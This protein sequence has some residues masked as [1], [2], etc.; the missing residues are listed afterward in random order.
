MGEQRAPQAEMGFLRWWQVL[1]VIGLVLGV[2]FWAY[3]YLTPGPQYSHASV[4]SALF[5]SGVVLLVG[6]ELLIRLSR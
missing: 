3:A 1:G 6:A 4:G 5:S 2:G